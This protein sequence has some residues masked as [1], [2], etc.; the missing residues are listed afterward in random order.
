MSKTFAELNKDVDNSSP[1]RAR[2]FLELD[3]KE[4]HEK[5]SPNFA[6]EILPRMTDAAVM[7][8]AKYIGW[9]EQ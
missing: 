1:A 4:K 9:E 7:R 5:Y 8:M 6:T 2:R 3:F